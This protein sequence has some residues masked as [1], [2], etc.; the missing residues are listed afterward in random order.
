MR[1]GEIIE[2]KT[3]EGND[4]LFIEKIK[5]ADNEVRTILSGLQGYVP[6]EEMRGKCIV[7]YNLKP[8]PIIGI[9]SEGMVMCVSNSDKS[10]INILWPTDDIPLGTRVSL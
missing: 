5:F 2:A 7:F 1:V 3:I 10:K 9:P 8:R 6:L 4:K